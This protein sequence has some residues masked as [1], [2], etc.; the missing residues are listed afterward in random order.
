[1]LQIWLKII[2]WQLTKEIFDKIPYLRQK[3]FVQTGRT[4]H[5]FLT[6][7]FKYYSLLSIGKQPVAPQFDFEGHFFLAYRSL[8]SSSNVDLAQFLSVRFVKKSMCAIWPIESERDLPLWRL[9]AAEA[10]VINLGPPPPR[11]LSPH[12]QTKKGGAAPAKT[13]DKQ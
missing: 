6:T 10:N 4:M 8:R 13:F 12:S 7:R 2:I 1:M 11:S 3:T 9:V 5:T